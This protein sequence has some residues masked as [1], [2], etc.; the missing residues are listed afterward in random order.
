MEDEYDEAEK[1]RES[2]RQKLGINENLEPQV[3]RKK[4]SD[5]TE[6]HIA[7]KKCVES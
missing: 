3:K 6:M 2:K 1:I 7:F 5:I 4:T